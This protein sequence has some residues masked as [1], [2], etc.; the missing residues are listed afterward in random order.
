MIVVFP[1]GGELLHVLA[2]DWLD[3]CV[4]MLLRFVFMFRSSRFI[5]VPTPC[6]SKH[7]QTTISLFCPVPVFPSYT[8]VGWL[9]SLRAATDAKEATELPSSAAWWWWPTMVTP[10][11]CSLCVLLCGDG[12]LN[13][14]LAPY[15][16]IYLET[17]LPV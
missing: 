11:R 5:C 15:G 2:G 17:K 12:F 3:H 16:E 14:I 7:R 1:M 13:F 4:F 6:L 10:F 8:N 9:S